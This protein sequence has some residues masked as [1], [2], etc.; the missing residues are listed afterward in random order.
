MKWGF[1]VKLLNL[2]CV[3]IFVKKV[4]V[5]IFESYNSREEREKRKIERG[6]MKWGV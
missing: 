2:Q 1:Q 5:L 3:K 6:K 4:L